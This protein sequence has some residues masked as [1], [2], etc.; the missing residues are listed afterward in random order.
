M[1]D[2]IEHNPTEEDLDK[3]RLAVIR[4][5]FD[6]HLN[7]VSGVFVNELDGTKTMKIV[8]EPK[9]KGDKSDD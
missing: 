4:L 2:F 3:I 1:I 5:L 6:E 8:M 9:L 7:L